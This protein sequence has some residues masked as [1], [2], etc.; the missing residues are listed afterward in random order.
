MIRGDVIDQ[1]L[2]D[3]QNPLRDEIDSWL[4]DELSQVGRA[5]IL[6][7]IVTEILREIDKALDLD[8]DGQLPDPAE[9]D[10]P[11]P[12]RSLGHRCPARRARAA[13]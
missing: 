11:P 6:H 13:G 10:S 8:P 5:K 2:K 9:G 12:G 1:W 4:P 3:N 7:G